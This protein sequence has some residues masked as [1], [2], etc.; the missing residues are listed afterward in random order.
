MFGVRNS[1]RWAKRRVLFGLARA[2]LRATPGARKNTPVQRS[3]WAGAPVLNMAVNAR[4]ERL[5][6]IE[7]DSL[8]YEPFYITDRFTHNLS[9]WARMPLVRHVLPYL[10]LV[11]ACRRYQRFHFF[12]DRGLLPPPADYR[13]NADELRLLRALG[14]EI[15]FWTYGADVRTR[16]T[17]QSLGEPNCCTECPA[18]GEACVC[19]QDRGT[20]NLTQIAE[21]ATA[22]FSM[23]DMIEY[24]RRSRN[25]LFFWPVDLDTDAGKRYAPRYPEADGTEPIRIVHA[26]NHRHFKGTRYLLAAVDRLKAEGYPL[27]LRLV[28]RVPND[29][30]MELYRTADLVFDQCLIGFHGYFAIEAMALG[31]PVMCYIR[32][33]DDY[34]LHPEECPIV[35]ARANQ[36]E[37]VLRELA[38]DRR[39]LHE[40]GVRGRK[41]VEKYFTLGAFAQRL[42]GAYQDL[43]AKCA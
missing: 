35:S 17:T 14:K 10:V 15:Y 23:G 18:P 9:R 19:D 30:A 41:Y 16:E 37:S 13:F 36:V 31:K 43:G 1:L 20:E 6:G 39:R 3:L 7:A 22:V 27:E 33:P 5:L 12:F 8:V 42:R 26:P 21:C 24:V 28:E 32:K 38:A 40:L 29:R 2:V 4:A 25:D 11:W 34:L